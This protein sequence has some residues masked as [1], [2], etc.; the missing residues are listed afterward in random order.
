[1]SLVIVDVTR[2][3]H[4]AYV[5]PAAIYVGTFGFPSGSPLNNSWDQGV[6]EDSSDVAAELDLISKVAPT[7]KSHSQEREG[8][9]AT[10]A[11]CF[12]LC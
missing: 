7:P 8:V 5:E 4:Q 12:H 11:T 10:R 1:M 3:C 9:A 2:R 6:L